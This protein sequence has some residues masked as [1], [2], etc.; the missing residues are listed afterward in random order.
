[1]A[2]S[3]DIRAEIASVLNQK[4]DVRDGQV[5][6]K[7]ED[8]VLAGGS[9][10]LTAAMLYADLADSTALAMYDRQLAARIFKAFLAS[11]TRIIRAEG[12][13]IRSFD[14]DRVM[15]IFIG[16]T[17]NTSATK[18]ALKINWVFLNQLKPQFDQRYEK[19][20]DGTHPL[21]H[22]CGVDCGPILVV[23]SGIR[24]NND[25]VWVGRAPNVAAKLSGIRDKPYNTY[26]TGEVYDSLAEEAKFG[27]QPRSNMWEER[28]WT[29]GPVKRVFCSSF[30]WV[31]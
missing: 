27:G 28:S 24:N 26:I 31:I 10:N 8:V 4:W 23:R 6:P 14:G 25:L 3:D 13:H 22:C 19:L 5:V 9:V 11:T 2:I 30:W 1:M 21:G 17:K 12:G 20:R 7:T 15:G 16:N 29:A 18:A